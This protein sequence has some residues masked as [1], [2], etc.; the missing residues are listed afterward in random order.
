MEANS[1]KYS[2]G[3]HGQNGNG[4][5]EK[6]QSSAPKIYEEFRIRSQMLYQ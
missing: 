2:V 4:I 1:D 3:K 5:N 6:K